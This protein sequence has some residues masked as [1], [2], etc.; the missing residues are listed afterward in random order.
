MALPEGIRMNDDGDVVFEGPS[1]Q[2]LLSHLVMRAKFA[3]PFEPI[4]FLNPWLAELAT[5]L[6]QRVRAPWGPARPARS[7]SFR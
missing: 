5:G 6:T 1:G 2:M 4:A 7:T 3:Q